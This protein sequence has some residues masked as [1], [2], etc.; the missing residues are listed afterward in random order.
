MAERSELRAALG[1]APS[2]PPPSK[3]NDATLKTYTVAKEREANPQAYAR[4]SAEDDAML[5][6]LYGEGMP[7]KALAAHFGRRRSAI[8]SRI[9]KLEL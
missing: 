1:H 5:E 3:P 7:K 9:R 6:K 4:W 2:V 8:D